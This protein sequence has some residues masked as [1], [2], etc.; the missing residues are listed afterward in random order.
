MNKNKIDK[1]TPTSHYQYYYER[2]FFRKYLL[3]WVYIFRYII[4]SITNYDMIIQ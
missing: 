3:S 1:Q 4:G 2:L